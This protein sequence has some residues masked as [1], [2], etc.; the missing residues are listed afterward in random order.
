MIARLL[1]I[2]QGDLK[3]CLGLTQLDTS[4]SQNPKGFFSQQ[5]DTLPQ[6]AM[7]YAENS[8]GSDFKGHAL[9]HNKISK[10]DT[11]LLRDLIQI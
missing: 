9:R 7:I 11:N 1:L 8:Y 6:T 4:D 3:R 10:K 2:F 5:S